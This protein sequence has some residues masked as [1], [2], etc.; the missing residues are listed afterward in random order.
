MPPTPSAPGLHGCAARVLCIRNGGA[1]TFAPLPCFEGTVLAVPAPLAA[2]SLRLCMPGAGKQQVRVV[3]H[4]RGRI[5][6]DQRAVD[7]SVRQALHDAVS[8]QLEERG[9]RGAQLLSDT[10]DDDIILKKVCELTR[11]SV[12]SLA[13]V[14][15]HTARRC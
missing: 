6:V 5:H 3:V 4:L 13:R 15:P 12:H 8:C 9:P 10:C 1:S 11:T 2:S 7:R 14:R